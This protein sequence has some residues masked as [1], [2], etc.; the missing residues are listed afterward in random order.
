MIEDKNKT[1]D[2]LLKKDSSIIQFESPKADEKNTHGTGCS[3]S[4]SIASLLAK[5]CSLEE[6]IK[7]AKNYIYEAIKNAPNLGRGNGPINHSLI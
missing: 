1:I 2:V 4:S 6:S 3:Y 5:N 7:Q